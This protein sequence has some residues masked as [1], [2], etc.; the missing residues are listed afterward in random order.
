VRLRQVQGEPAVN[1]RVA[2]LAVGG[3]AASRSVGGEAVEQARTA[4]R[5]ERSKPQPR[6]R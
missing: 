5:R 2:A 6:D 3:S 4:Y 1:A